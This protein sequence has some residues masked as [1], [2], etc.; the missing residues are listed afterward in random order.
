MLNFLERG[1]R[2]VLPPNYAYD[3]LRKNIFVLFMNW[4]DFI[5]WLSFLRYWAKI[6]NFPT[7][8]VINYKLILAFLSSRF[9]QDQKESGQTFEYLK[10][11]NKKI[12]KM[13]HHF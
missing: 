4:S 10:N 9:L 6:I 5:V 2:L 3:F 12:K 11:K 8:N 7:D 1:P 13:F